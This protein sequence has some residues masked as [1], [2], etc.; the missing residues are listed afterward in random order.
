MAPA[1]VGDHGP[2]RLTAGEALLRLA[3]KARP[4]VRA[5]QR[6]RVRQARDPPQMSPQRAPPG[7]GEA[8]RGVPYRGEAHD[9][10]APGPPPH[11]IVGH[12][13]DRTQTATEVAEHYSPEIAEK[14]RR[15]YAADFALFGYSTDLA[16][17][18]EPPTGTRQADA[19]I[20]A[21]ET[22]SPALRTLIAA[23][24]LS[25]AERH[26]EALE[27]LGAALKSDAGGLDPAPELAIDAGEICLELGDIDAAEAHIRQAIAGNGTALRYRLMLV[28]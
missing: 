13:P 11:E 14:V 21:G 12:L 28:D 20:P 22:V 1:Q 25:L 5:G 6:S 4:R 24:Q 10:V 23:W 17:A 16:D 8:A 19:G 27:I 15:R 2:R 18:C 3:A 9:Q 7:G 26:A